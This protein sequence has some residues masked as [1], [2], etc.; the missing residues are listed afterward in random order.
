MN[1]GIGFDEMFDRFRLITE[2]A[3]QGN[4]PPY[5]II[6][7]KENESIIELAVAGFSEHDLDIEVD[8]N[9]LTINGNKDVKLDDEKYR[10]KGIAYRN[11]TRTFALADYIQ[12]NGAS[13]DCGILRVYLERVVPEELKP[14]KIKIISDTQLLTET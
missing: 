9:K 1:L 5:N 2:H 4:Y 8:G 13:V 12:V 10:H 11:F 6:Q 3:S 7:E 14:K